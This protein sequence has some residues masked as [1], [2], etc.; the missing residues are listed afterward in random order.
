MYII[1]I[2]CA[3]L[4]VIGG[5]TCYFCWPEANAALSQLGALTEQ[6]QREIEANDRRIDQLEEYAN[7]QKKR[8]HKI[9]NSIS[10]LEESVASKLNK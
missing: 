9:D 3:V 5:I 4:L 1:I 10:Q 8:L 2:I 7:K 6:Q